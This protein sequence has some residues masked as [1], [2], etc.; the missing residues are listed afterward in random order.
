[1]TAQQIKSEWAAASALLNSIADDTTETGALIRQIH[2]SIVSLVSEI[3]RLEIANAAKDAQIDRL[4]IQI[5]R[6][7]AA[8]ESAKRLNTMGA[9]ELLALSEF[10]LGGK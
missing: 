6:Q 7:Q 1:M 4:K 8:I 10:S 5:G 2:E 9:T 3:Q